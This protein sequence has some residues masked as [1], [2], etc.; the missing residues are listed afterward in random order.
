MGEQRFVIAERARKRARFESE[1]VGGSGSEKVEVSGL[2]YK[3]WNGQEKEEEEEGQL[4]NKV[5]DG[6]YYEKKLFEYLDYLEQ[7]EKSKKTILKYKADVKKFLNHKG[8]KHM[9]KRAVISW[10]ES[11]MKEYAPTS[12]NSMLVAVNGFLEWQE[13]Y[14][15]KVKLLKVQ[16]EIYTRPEKE[17]TQREYA[18]LVRTA[19]ERGNNKLGL[20]IQTI[21]GTGI[22]VSE[23]K[24]ITVSGVKTGRVN[25]TAKG[26]SR[27]VFIPKGLMVKLAAY[28]KE[29]NIESGMVFL[30]R[31]GREINR[32]Y[33]WRM[34][35]GLCEEAKV[36]KEKAYPH[37]LRHL[38]ARSYY[39]LDKDIS[40]LADLLGHSSINTT[41][42]YTIE[43]GKEHIKLLEKMELII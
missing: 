20:I 42:I 10:K 1:K 9:D 33:I 22:R 37:N 19:Y 23:L 29:K 27:T 32:T 11:I 5:S 4:E 15:E 26:K 13:L 43:S 14:K 6:A 12:V 18:R 24:Y 41:R 21:C 31:T 3:K 39:K 17:L 28:C 40:R 2:K 8:E 34:M 35:K 30:S 16:R 38:F 25:A 36:E 7:E